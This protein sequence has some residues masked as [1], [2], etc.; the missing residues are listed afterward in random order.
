MSLVERQIPRIHPTAIV[1][2]GAVLAD[3]V[4][5]GPYSV[6][7]EH[8]TVGK[9]CRIGAHCLLDGHTTIGKNNRFF[10][11]AVIGSIP[12]DLKYKGEESRLTIGDHN[13]F[14]EYATVNL[15]TA[16]GG[17]E[18]KIGN[19]VLMMAY[20]HVAHDCQV[21]DGAIL[22]NGVQIAGHVVIGERA[23]ISGM[24]GVSQFVHIGKLAL[25]GA[26]SKATQDVLPFTISDGRPLETYALNKVG[27]ERAG[28]SRETQRFLSKALR[29]LLR[30]GLS[31]PNALRQIEEELPP[32]P[33]VRYLVQFV[34]ASKH[35]F[36]GAAKKKGL[37]WSVSV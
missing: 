21:Q 34:R 5:V 22:S 18:T 7:G 1:H 10:T 17:G 20:A 27:L 26:I 19:H 4:E 32:D 16:G 11:G 37:S 12:Q 35:G 36:S 24:A 13:I 8:V 15:G 33:E 28:V 23:I 9:G 3:D 25:V 2:E 29:L 6:I 14:R 31:V 30:S